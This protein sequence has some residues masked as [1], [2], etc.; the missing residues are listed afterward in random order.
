MNASSPA[1]VRNERYANASSLTNPSA[2]NSLHQ[3]ISK[4]EEANKK[5]ENYVH[6]TSLA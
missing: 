4:L 6:L 1:R 5:V 3:C 2:N